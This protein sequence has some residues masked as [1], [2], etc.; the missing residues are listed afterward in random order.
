MNEQFL[1]QALAELV[2][3]QGVALGLVVTALA[4]QLD[5]KTLAADLEALIRSAKNQPSLPGLVD[6]IASHA[7]LAAQA[8]AAQQRNGAH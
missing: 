3:S 7:H 6:R 4:R 1:K 5:A 2:E 8:V